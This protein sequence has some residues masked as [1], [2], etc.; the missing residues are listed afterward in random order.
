VGCLECNNE[1]LGSMNFFHPMPVKGMLPIFF[2]AVQYN[3]DE[4]HHLSQL[5]ALSIKC[6]QF[7]D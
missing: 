1:P 3:L 6:V 4:F 7:L 5:L 2:L